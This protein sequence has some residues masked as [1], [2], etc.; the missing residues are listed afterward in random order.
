MSEDVVEEPFRSATEKVEAS[1][2]EAVEE[3]RARVSKAK[4]DALK[5]VPA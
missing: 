1:H 2:Q 5:K 3:L 4:S